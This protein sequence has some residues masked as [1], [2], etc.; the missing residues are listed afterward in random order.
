YF[1]RLVK[2]PCRIR[3]SIQAFCCS[4]NVMVLRTFGMRV[5][6]SGVRQVQRMIAPR[7]AGRNSRFPLRR[8]RGGSVSRGRCGTAIENWAVFIEGPPLDGESG[9][10]MLEALWSSRVRRAPKHLGRVTSYASH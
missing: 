3:A 7:R 6:P 4:V 1:E 9:I 2:P 8:A 10:G 5:I